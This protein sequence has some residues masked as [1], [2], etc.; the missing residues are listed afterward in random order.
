M[1]DTSEHFIKT[2]NTTTLVKKS[3]STLLLVGCEKT[4]QKRMCKY[5]TVYQMIHSKKQKKI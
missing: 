3:T 5:F 1:Y 2:N 4:F